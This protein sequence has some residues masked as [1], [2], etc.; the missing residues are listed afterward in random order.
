MFG[1][2]GKGSANREREDN[3]TTKSVINKEL[4]MVEGVVNG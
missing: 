3:A 4:V 2:R 1:P